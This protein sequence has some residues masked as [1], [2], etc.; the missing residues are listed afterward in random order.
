MFVTE[1]CKCLTNKEYPEDLANF[2]NTDLNHLRSTLFFQFP[3]K[4]FQKDS[5]D[6]KQPDK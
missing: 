1:F 4:R 3:E 6:F 5:D 2:A